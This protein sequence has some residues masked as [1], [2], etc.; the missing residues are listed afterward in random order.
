MTDTLKT[1]IQD[2][3]SKITEARK[4]DLTYT[5]L[6]RKGRNSLPKGD[7]KVTRVEVLLKNNTR[8]G[9]LATIAK[10]MAA[11]LIKY[12]E[13][14][15][16][17]E[18][19]KASKKADIFA[20]AEELFDEGDEAFVRVIKTL[21]C[22][23]VISKQTSR[24]DV[25]KEQLIEMLKT[26]F[27]ESVDLIDEIVEACTKISEVESKITP[28]LN[29]S[30][31]ITEGKILSKLFNRAIQKIKDIVS[32][33]ISYIKDK[34]KVID[35]NLFKVVDELT[36]EE[37]DEYF[38]ALEKYDN[39]NDNESSSEIIKEFIASKEEK[40]KYVIDTINNANDKQI[41]ETVKFMQ[42]F[43]WKYR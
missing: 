26:A 19:L 37:K 21:E 36:P 9:N 15:K 11:S 38:K 33:T 8:Y 10:N 28:E 23:L 1:R 40:I 20:E 35:E 2:S 29:E 34:N 18:E 22:S 27:N 13:A 24:K 6:D 5:D 25:D 4:K 30:Q 31:T 39:I 43:L 16:E 42:T 41:D 14:K 32:S 7:E 17:L 3:Y 12:Q